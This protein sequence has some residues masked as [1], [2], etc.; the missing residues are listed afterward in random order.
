MNLAEI[1]IRSKTS[2]LVLATLM[3]LGGLNAYQSLGR[4]E[5]PAFTIK[6]ALIITPYPGATAEEVEEEV[7]DLI[8][9]AVQKLGQLDEIE[10]RSEAGLSTVTATIKDKYDQETL[11]QVWDELRRKVGDVQKQL[12]PGAGPS[13]VI[14]DFGD[15]FG[16]LFAIT[17]ENPADYTYAELEDIAEFLQRELLLIEDVAKIDVVGAQPE[18]IYVEMSRSRMAQ[19]AIP[20]EAIYQALASKN[21]VSNAGNVRVGAEYVPLRPTGEFQTIEEMGELLISNLGP[22]TSAERRRLVR[23][24]DVAE[25]TRGYQDPPSSILRVDG[26]PAVALAISTVTGGNVVNMGTALNAR[27]IELQPQLPAGIQFHKIAIQSEA[28]S[29]A[30]NGFVV[31]LLEAVAIVIVVLV[32]FMGVQ[33]GMLIGAVLFITIAGTFIFMQMQGVMLERISLGALIIAL[34]MLVD[35]AIVVTEGMLVRIQKGED[36][37]EAAKAVVSQNSMPLLGATV[38]AVIAFAAIG[39][40][41][42]STGEYCRSL[43]QVILISLMLSWVTAVTLTP[44]FCKM[45][46]KVK[47]GGDGSDDPYASPFYQIYR[48]ILVGC[49]RFRWATVIVMLGLLAL[50][51]V[52]FK[53][54][55]DQSFFP[56]STRPQFMLDFWLPEGTHIRDSENEAAKV[57][58][59]L[60]DLEGVTGV[61]TSVGRGLPRFLLTYA[62]E[63]ANSSYTF[64]LISV[65]DYKTIDGLVDKIL[66][67]LAT[68]FPEAIPIPY[69]F[70]LGPGDALKIQARF[71]GPDRAVLRELA[72]QAI[73]V[74]HEDGGLMGMQTDWRE[75][76]KVYRPILAEA[77]A[78]NSGI[79]RP[80]VAAVLQEAFDGV[81]AG[82]FREGDTLLPIISRPPASERGDII[83]IQNLQIWSPAAGRN[84]P[85][86]QVIEDYETAFEDSIIYRKDRKRTI[87]I[88]ST[89]IKGNASIA[90]AR[91]QSKI[92]SIEVPLGY[93]FEWGGEYENSRDA[94]AAMAGSIPVFAL[95]M[96][97]I[98]IL[99]FDALRQ[100]IIIFLCVPLAIIGVTAGLMATG[101]PFG[102]MALLGG[103]SLSGMLIKN[104]IV[105][106][107]QID[108]E[109]REGKDKYNA[110]VDSGVSRMRPVLMAAATTVLGMIPLLMDAFFVS[111]A[112]T[113]MAGLT[114]ASVLTLIVVPV[115]YSIFFG[116]DTSRAT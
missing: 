101:Q 55:V 103:L 52:G 111:M 106:I 68:K 92:E 4:L 35:N 61:T 44:L 16:V 94:R 47:G 36:R 59:Y 49:L 28:V 77:Q 89:P 57:E 56:A 79:D 62:A 5:D 63:K 64:F 104:S 74:M 112:V 84:I 43:F 60:M 65:D 41:K 14:D 73:G 34:G 66:A 6:D 2:T 96:F 45:F 50:S 13:T 70:M 72:E 3:V 10:S 9:K 87:T 20:K 39:T 81:P 69:K 97:L 95:F 115:L 12:P 1:S 17:S 25:I 82:L 40:S 38:V 85:L 18:V 116:V 99:L 23:L 27:M 51:F 86:D 29:V 80:Q 54:G 33:S 7:S 22:A 30:I 108:L 15:V 58:E 24:R 19:F 37:L 107:D 114:F 48:K 11:P 88:K 93:T 42:D 102:F 105:L 76:V 26:K 83:E 75:M 46:L 98:T 109:I 78:R 113:I 21:L 91:I 67:D 71:S 110:I 31:S 100:P 90:M 53:Y 8:E 32:I